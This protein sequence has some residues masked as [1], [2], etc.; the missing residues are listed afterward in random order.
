MLTYAY[1]CI[2]RISDIMLLTILIRKLFFQEQDKI[3]RIKVSWPSRI[4][5]TLIAL[6]A[7]TSFMKPPFRRRA[8]QPQRWCS[9]RR[10]AGVPPRSPPV[11][12]Q[13]PRSENTSSTPHMP[14]RYS[15]KYTYRK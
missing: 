9:P 6:K 11:R 3:K 12:I 15:S 2:F 4:Y 10:G 7:Q 1:V 14:I 5:S 13:V 8:Q